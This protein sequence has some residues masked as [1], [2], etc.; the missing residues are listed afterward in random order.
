MSELAHKCAP[1]GQNQDSEVDQVLIAKASGLFNIDLHFE[2][3]YIASHPIHGIKKVHCR[4]A[5]D[6]IFKRKEK[7]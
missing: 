5:K 3:Y 4:H 7:F 6:N 1:C 2:H